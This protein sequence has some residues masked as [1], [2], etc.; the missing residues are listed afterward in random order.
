MPPVFIC[1]VVIVASFVGRCGPGF[2]GRAWS[3]FPASESRPRGRIPPP[4]CRPLLPAPDDWP[5]LRD[6]PQILMPDRPPAKVSEPRP[7]VVV[8]RLVCL[9]FPLRQICYTP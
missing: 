2:P 7:C 1:M 4:L 6:E 9:P 3:V 8:E 5:V